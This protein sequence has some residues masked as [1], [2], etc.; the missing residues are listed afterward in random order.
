[1]H[2]LSPK[3]FNFYGFKSEE[4]TTWGGCRCFNNSLQI[5]FSVQAV[6][7]MQKPSANDTAKV[8]DVQAITSSGDIAE[9]NAYLGRPLSLRTRIAGWTLDHAA[10]P[11][12]Q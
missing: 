11:C 4:V 5:A 7:Y 10:L 12:C 8:P 6:R 9:E 2:A 1:M 3:W